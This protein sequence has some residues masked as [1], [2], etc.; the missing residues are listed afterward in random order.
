MEVVPSSSRRSRSALTLISD[1]SQLVWG[2][3]R[4][5]AEQMCVPGWKS[6]FIP[7]CCGWL[8]Y[9]ALMLMLGPFVGIQ[10]PPV[11]IP[12][13]TCWFPHTVTLYDDAVPRLRVCS[14]SFCSLILVR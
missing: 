14:S 13:F 1:L 2:G 8:P 11:L 10:E 6:S 9:G 3:K 4:V 7:V 12:V 5:C